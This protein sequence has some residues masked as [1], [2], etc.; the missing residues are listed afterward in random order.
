MKWICLKR[1]SRCALFH[2]RWRKVAGQI[3]DLP[4]R[5]VVARDDLS[6]QLK[7]SDLVLNG[8]IYTFISLLCHHPQEHMVQP[9]LP[10][11]RKRCILI[12]GLMLVFVFHVFHHE[13]WER[14]TFESI[15]VVKWPSDDEDPA[16]II[17]KNVWRWSNNVVFALCHQRTAPFSLSLLDCLGTSFFLFTAADSQRR[18]SYPNDEKSDVVRGRSKRNEG[19]EAGTMVRLFW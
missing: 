7:T 19:W 16:R 10:G 12:H 11:C 2:L 1:N 17:P 6:H 9:P 18:V 14:T 5:A 13:R 4:R 3:L 15:D 8:L